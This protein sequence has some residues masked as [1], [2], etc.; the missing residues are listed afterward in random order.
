M[1]TERHTMVNLLVERDKEK[2]YIS[3][4]INMFT[5]E[6]FLR[7][8]NMVMESILILRRAHMKVSFLKDF[9]QVLENK[10]FQKEIFMRDIGKITEKME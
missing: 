2:V 7:T 1:R 9:E 4:E 6:A 3:I 5:K 10:S 8:L